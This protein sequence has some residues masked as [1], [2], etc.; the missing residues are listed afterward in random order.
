MSYA[1]LYEF[2]QTQR[3]HIGRNVVR[4]R[5]LQIT[6]LPR[7]PVTI[8][9]IDTAH[10]RGFYLSAKNPE[11]RMV[12]QF[13]GHLIA[14]ARGLNRCW[15]RFVVVKEMMHLFGDETNAVDSGELFEE[16]LQDFAVS[17]ADTSP[18]MSSEY[19]CF[20]MALGALCPEQKRLEYQEKRLNQEIDDYAIALELRIPQQYVTRL[21]ERRYK[22]NIDRLL[23]S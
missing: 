17:S 8:V 2:C 11:N 21:F 10:C 9:D 7:I 3:L 19:D 13:G 4:D 1:D 20:W 6:G 12:Q 16:L 23:A 22:P 15:Q 5:I 14:V 18:Q